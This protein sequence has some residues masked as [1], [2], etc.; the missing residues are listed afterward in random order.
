MSANRGGKAMT[1]NSFDR[2]AGLT[3][4]SAL[5]LPLGVSTVALFSRNARSQQPA[6]GGVL[7][8]VAYANPSSLDPSTG[9]SGADHAFLWP[10]F[11][12]L[13]DVEPTT[14]NPVPGLAES[15][16]YPDPTTLVLN[17]RTG[18][19]FHD[20]T[21]FDAAA[22]K[23]N[24]D[25]MLSNP[26]ST[27]KGEV[28]TIKSVEI[29]NQSRVIFKL[30]EPDTSLPLAMSDRIGMMSSP[31]AFDALGVAYDRKPVGT[32]AYEFVE[33]VDGDKVVLRRNPKYWKPGLPFLDGLEMK[34]IVDA[35]TGLRSVMSGQA[36]FVYRVSPHQTP[37]V[38]SS[39]N[40]VLVTNP[41]LYCQLIYLNCSRPP[42]DDKRIRQALNLAIDR[43]AYNKVVTAGLGEVAPTV[44]PKRHWAYDA[45]AAAMYPYDI[46][47][48]RK[49]MAEAGFSNGLELH[50]NTASDP[51]T[52]QRMEIIAAQLSKIG[53]RLKYSV[54]SL[55]QSN[56]TWNDGVGDIRL[57]AWT[58]RPDP[59]M[60]FAALY[61]P[62]GFFNRGGAEPSKELTRAI[63]DSRSST[64]INVRKEAFSRAARLEREVAMSLPL[65]FESE[66][67][68]HHKKVKGYV[69]NLIGKP[70]FDGVWIDAKI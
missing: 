65:V 68:V 34:V 54:S 69:S 66:V 6:R 23:A 26:K 25:H 59:S 1:A 63:K 30:K 17:L 35:N 10:I 61:S 20:G 2:S 8:V 50:S 18:V 45:Q 51:F 31:K 64:D 3:R 33:W 56:Q 49:L 21:P 38:K 53:I 52:T 19:A 43:E 32:G 39:S 29:E 42:L 57:T 46:D 70:R 62:E 13:V 11:D 48:A 14:L 37:V 55:A 27:V 40:F 7:R 58:G 60:T 28:S 15:W 44:L 24:F 9:R 47:R 22:V 5:I 67:V 16:N 41:T 36:D 12:T 4:R